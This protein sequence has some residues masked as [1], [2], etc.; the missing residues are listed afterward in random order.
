MGLEW[1]RWGR[2]K[3]RQQKENNQN[4]EPSSYVN[5]TVECK[6][7]YV[8]RTHFNIYSIFPHI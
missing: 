5:S 4:S 1:V 2:K 8:S 6:K 3:H 7:K